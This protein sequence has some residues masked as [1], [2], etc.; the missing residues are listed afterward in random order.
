M[1]S[2]LG[3]GATK[4]NLPE[5]HTRFQKCHTGLKCIFNYNRTASKM[6]QWSG[7]REETASAGWWEMKTRQMKVGYDPFDPWLPSLPAHSPGSG[8]RLVG[9]F[10]RFRVC[11]SLPPGTSGQARSCGQGLP[12]VERAAAVC[13]YMHGQHGGTVQC[14]GVTWVCEWRVCG[15][16]EEE[17]FRVWGGQAEGE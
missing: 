12:H 2:S 9:R 3:L 13:G 6:K 4:K 11:L 8:W 15:A 14:T 5:E 10:K 7:G 16:Q 1:A 17:T